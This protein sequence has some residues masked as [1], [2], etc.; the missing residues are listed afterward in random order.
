MTAAARIQGSTLTGG[1]L[2]AFVDSDE[3]QRLPLGKLISGQLGKHKLLICAVVR[4][5]AT[6]VPAAGVALR[7][8]YSVLT[9]VEQTAPEAAATILGHPHVGSWAARCLRQL[10]N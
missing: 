2:A 1:D 4:F 10:S 7:Q 5:G 3:A 9:A 6:A 8:H